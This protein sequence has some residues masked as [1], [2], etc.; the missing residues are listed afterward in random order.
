MI[1]I[2]L[3]GRIAVVTGSSAGI[4]RAS[5]VTLANAGADLIVVARRRPA[6]DELVERFGADRV[7]AVEADLT[8]A[9]GT[10]R[11]VDAVAAAG[12]LDILVNAAGGS[13]TVALDSGDDAWAEA[14]ELNFGSL[15]RLTHAVLP[16]LIAAGDNGRVIAI[17]GSSEPAPN[18]VF[19]DA[20]RSSALNAANSAKAAVHA[21]AKGLSRE[22]GQYGVTVNSVAPGSVV[23]EQLLKIFPTTQDQARHVAE[24]GIPMGRFGRPEEVADM[25]LFLASP[26]A[27]YVTG[28]IIHVDGGKR[29][30]AF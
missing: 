13:R 1:G 12:R 4:G 21:W 11:V 26:L 10:A 18:P 8:T 14:M 17:T 20:G 6:L 7:T 23:T 15:R 27:G 9:Q 29:R 19:G 5:A 25:V 16:S 2:D 24:L 3:S 22:L 30:Y 28:E